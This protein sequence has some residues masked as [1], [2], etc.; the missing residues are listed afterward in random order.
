MNLLTRLLLIVAVL[1]FVA[2]QLALLHSANALSLKVPAAPSAV[3]T[4]QLLDRA[5]GDEYV[6]RDR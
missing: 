5:D 4:A 2:G 3:S 6:S 1:L